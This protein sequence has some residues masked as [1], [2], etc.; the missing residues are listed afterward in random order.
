MRD[1][2]RSQNTID[3]DSGKYS[4]ALGTVFV[5]I[6]RECEKCGDYVINAVEAKMGKREDADNF[7]ALEIDHQ[8]K[9]ATL[10]GKPI[11]F[12][13]TEFELLSLLVSNPGRVFSKEELLESIWP[14]D[15]PA[16][17]KDV[18][19]SIKDIRAKLGDVAGHITLK[20]GFGYYFE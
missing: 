2:L 8:R 18:D 6:V 13:K 14:K 5:D 19:G 20:P 11:D 16:G 17:I 12:T 7:G 9:T 1:K 4:F 15:E 3:V 10:Y